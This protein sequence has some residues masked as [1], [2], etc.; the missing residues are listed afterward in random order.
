[1]N[2]C[3]LVAPQRTRVEARNEWLAYDGFRSPHPTVETK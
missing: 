1:M 2:G 3:G